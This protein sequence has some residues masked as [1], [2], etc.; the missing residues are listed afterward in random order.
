[1]GRR[2]KRRSAL[3]ADLAVTI[4]GVVGLLGF[5]VAARMDNPN[6]SLFYAFAFV[7][8]FIFGG[9]KLWLPW[10]LSKRAAVKRNSARQEVRSAFRDA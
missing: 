4:L 7:W 6:A 10:Q 3:A 8:F 2:A 1:M 9:I 5:L